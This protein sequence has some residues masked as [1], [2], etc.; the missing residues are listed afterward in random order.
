MLLWSNT[1]MKFEKFQTIIEFNRRNQ[2][3]VAEKVR[4]F[5]FKMG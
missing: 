3:T 5:Y 2:E 4:D 1:D